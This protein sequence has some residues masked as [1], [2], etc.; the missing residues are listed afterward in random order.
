M[1]ISFRIYMGFVFLLF[2]TIFLSVYADYTAITKCEN[3]G[4]VW[5]TKR[6]CINPAAIVETD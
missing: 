2:V 6:I 5:V 4:G 1:E 3:S